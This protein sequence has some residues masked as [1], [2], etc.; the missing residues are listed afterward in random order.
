[1]M[2]VLGGVAAPA[3]MQGQGHGSAVGACFMDELRHR[4]G[5]D[6]GVVEG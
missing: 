3:R 2:R 4:S 1:M 6:S 5:E